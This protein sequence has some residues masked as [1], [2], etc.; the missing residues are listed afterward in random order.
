MYGRPPSQSK[1]RAALEPAYNIRAGQTRPSQPTI[2]SSPAV[3]A[4]TIRIQAPWA[5]DP[6]PSSCTGAY[7][8]ARVIEH[9][10][11]RKPVPNP[12]SRQ[13]RSRNARRIV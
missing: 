7:L 2:A 13:Q 10:L 3:D 9:V 5:R 6:E 11:F 4:I 12:T 8:S 1:E